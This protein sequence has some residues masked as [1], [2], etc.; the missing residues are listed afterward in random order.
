MKRRKITIVATCFLGIGVFWFLGV[1]ASVFFEVCPDCGYTKQVAK[2][3]I[4][5]VSVWEWASDE[6]ETLV[7]K[8]AADLGAPCLHPRYQRLHLQ[9]RWGLLIC[10]WP[11]RDDLLRVSGEPTHRYTEEVRERLRAAAREN[12]SLGEEFLE[13]VVRKHNWEYWHSFLDR[14]WAGVK[15]DEGG[16]ENE[17]PPPN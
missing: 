7:Q 9:R 15:A 10:T 6:E 12:P 5:S 17:A 1:D 8:V 4:L 2:A 16:A 11:C 13:E 3:R 14:M